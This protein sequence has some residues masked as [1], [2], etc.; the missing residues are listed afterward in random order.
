MTA[1][2]CSSV[3]CPEGCSE[4][5]AMLNEQRHTREFITE[6][7]TNHLPHIYDRLGEIQVWFNRVLVALVFVLFGI[8]AQLFK[9]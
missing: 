3:D 7:K 4:H 6:I 5:S 9:S 2:K 1:K 8:I